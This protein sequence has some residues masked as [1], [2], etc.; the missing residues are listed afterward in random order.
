MLEL[1]AVASSMSWF[2]VNVWFTPLILVVKVAPF[3]SKAYSTVPFGR[4]FVGAKLPQGV[5]EE[6]LRKEKDSAGGPKSMLAT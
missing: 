6:Q 3:S 4:F 5:I 2:G 1:G